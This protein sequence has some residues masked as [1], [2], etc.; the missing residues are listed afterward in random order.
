MDRADLVRLAG[1]PSMSVSGVESSV[2][3]ETYWYRVGADT[4]TIILRG[5]KIASI[6]GTEKLAA[7]Q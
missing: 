6:S 1:K 2:L 5:G 4:V 3:V 7:K